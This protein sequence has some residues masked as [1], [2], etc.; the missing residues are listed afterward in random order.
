MLHEPLLHELPHLESCVRATHWNRKPFH[1]KRFGS[2][3]TRAASPE[4]ALL[5]STYQK[6]WHLTRVLQ[7]IAL[8]QGP[9]GLFEVV[10]TDDG[11]TDDTHRIV[12]EFAKSVRF[13]VTL[14]THEHVRFQ[15]A[16]CRNEGAIVSTAPYLLF[17]DGDC[18]LPPDHVL[19]HL[20]HR[21]PGRAMCGYCIRLDR[22]TS[23]RFDADVIRS[24]EY[25]R[26]VSRPQARL[27][28]KRDRKAR[29]YRLIRHRSKPKL[30]GGNCAVWRTDFESV[31]GFHEIFEGWGGEDTDL[32][33]RLRRVGVPVESILRWTHTYHLWHAPDA[34]APQ[35]IRDGVN[36]VYLERSFRFAR[37]MNG[38]E[39]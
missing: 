12:E 14:T 10:V 19:A 24:G 31:N 16:R 11:S 18:V 3:R 7:S 6:P 27:L 5:V 21:Q 20:Q 30:A 22:A 17:L 23:E 13:P 4:I 26:W 36:H 9:S 35:R 28:A 29:F 39:T 32:G 25:M 15:L 33:L 1:V 38:L 37:C 34:T 8:Q 2:G